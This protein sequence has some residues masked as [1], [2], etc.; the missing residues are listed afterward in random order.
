MSKSVIEKMIDLGDVNA[1]KYVARLETAITKILF[2]AAGNAHPVVQEVYEIA[3]EAVNAF[4]EK[5]K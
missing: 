1:A 5:G 3:K 2:A 4:D